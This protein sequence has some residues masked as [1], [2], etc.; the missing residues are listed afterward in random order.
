MKEEKLYWGED[1]EKMRCEFDNDKGL[2]D[3][4]NIAKTIQMQIENESGNF[5][6]SKME[7]I[8]LGKYDNHLTILNHYCYDDKDTYVEALP[9][10]RKDLERVYNG[11]FSVYKTKMEIEE[12]K[13]ARDEFIDEER[14]I[15]DEI[16]NSRNS[17][18]MGLG[19]EK[20]DKFIERKEKEKHE[21][22]KEGEEMGE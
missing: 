2:I 9:R 22:V 5:D 19:F 16:I 3:L 10:F 8:L 6:K 21:K 7:K 20:W 18:E 4:F 1:L 13:K 17:E 14:K 12:E 11:E 15:F